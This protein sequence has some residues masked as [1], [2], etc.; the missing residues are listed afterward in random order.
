VRLAAIFFLL[1]ALCFSQAGTLEGCI[2]DA[3]G[4]PLPMANIYLSNGHQ[5]YYG[6][7]SDE[8][9]WFSLIL[10]KEYLHDTLHVSFVGF[11]TINVLVDTTRATPGLSIVLHEQPVQL[12]EVNVTALPADEYVRRCVFAVSRNYSGV[13]FLNRAFH[14]QSTQENGVFNGLRQSY[15]TVIDD[16]ASGNPL[17]TI[18][19]D[20]ADSYD[21]L[22]LHFL[23]RI[24]HCFTPDFV[25][26]RFHFVNEQNFGE[27]IFTF[28][29]D[30]S[31][32]PGYMVIRAE[33]IDGFAIISMLINEKNLAFEEVTYE[34]HWRENEYHNLNDSL[35]YTMGALKGKIRFQERRSKYFLNYITNVLDYTVYRKLTKKKMYTRTVENETVIYHSITIGGEDI[36][37]VKTPA[38]FSPENL[39]VNKEKYCLAAKALSRNMAFCR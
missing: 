38:T 28:D 10:P 4:R 14:W 8:N 37:L 9:G 13:S 3:K 32:L 5:R 17:L 33:R 22:P 25:R 24:E 27:W 23:D 29:N 21:A 7:M 15:V 6:T 31:V 1:P 20:S 19:S 39:I 34:Y 11:R 2:V 30:T 12:A 26:R 18:T 16:N 35:M 36:P